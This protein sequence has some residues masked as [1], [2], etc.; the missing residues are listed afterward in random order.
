[1]EVLDEFIKV[2]NEAIN[3]LVCRMSDSRVLTNLMRDAVCTFMEDEHGEHKE[4][5][6]KVLRQMGVDHRKDYT[7]YKHYFA[8]NVAQAI[9]FGLAIYLLPNRGRTVKN[10]TA[11]WTRICALLTEGTI[12]VVQDNTI[13]GVPNAD[14]NKTS[15]DRL[16]RQIEGLEAFLQVI[17]DSPSLDRQELLD[18]LVKACETAVRNGPQSEQYKKLAVVVVVNRLYGSNAHIE[19]RKQK[20][21]DLKTDPSMEGLRKLKEKFEQGNTIPSTGMALLQLQ[22]GENLAS[23]V[24]VHIPSAKSWPLSTHTVQTEFDPQTRVWHLTH[25]HCE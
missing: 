1:M 15:H 11:V 7:D 4:E 8:S 16:M 13:E 6:A 9:A 20:L 5:Y 22:S 14:E 24:K 17:C 21:D 2:N 19:G 18:K 10:S 3:A 12:R 23:L 25:P